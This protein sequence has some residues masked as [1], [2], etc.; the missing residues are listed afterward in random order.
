MNISPNSSDA[1]VD[2][3]GDHQQEAEDDELRVVAVGRAARTA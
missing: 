1:G 3:G 2:R